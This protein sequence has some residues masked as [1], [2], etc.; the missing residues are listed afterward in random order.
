MIGTDGNLRWQQTLESPSVAT[1]PALPVAEASTG[2]AAT[3]AGT[4]RPPA[5]TPAG[6]SDPSTRSS[7]TGDGGS[8]GLVSSGMPAAAAAAVL[9]Y[10]TNSRPRRLSP[11]Q[12][13][14]SSSTGGWFGVRQETE[15]ARPAE[16]EAE[17]LLSEA[18]M[19]QSGHLPTTDERGIKF[20]G[21]ESSESSELLLGT[22]SFGKEKVGG[23]D[24]GTLA[25]ADAV[26]MTRK[27]SFG[28]EVML[29]MC[30]GYYTT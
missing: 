3:T 26:T 13:E 10:W 21:S 8:G 16:A 30:P 6:A 17:S 27:D 2:A 23:K 7:A 14:T 24:K 15:R 28:D 22:S 9:R 4:Y 11:S 20:E 25:A 12:S 5:V 19:G 1:A 18:E 29:T